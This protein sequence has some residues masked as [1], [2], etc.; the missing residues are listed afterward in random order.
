MIAFILAMY[1]AME[2]SVYVPVGI[3]VVA[4]C[5]TVLSAVAAIAK[6]YNS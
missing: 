2:N 1:I 3:Q 4:W 6:A 5:L